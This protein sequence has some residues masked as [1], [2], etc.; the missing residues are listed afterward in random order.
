MIQDRIKTMNGKLIPWLS[1]ELE[2]RGWSHREL[3]RRA[4]I[5]QTAVS[6]VLAGERKAGWDFCAAIAGPLGETPEEI[7]RKA[8][9]IQRLNTE[10]D[11]ELIEMI[12]RLS[13][14]RR[15]MAMKLIKLLYQEQ[16]EEEAKKKRLYHEI[17]S[18]VNL[19]KALEQT[20]YQERINLLLFL[21]EWGKWKQ[22][23][24]PVNERIPVLL[25]I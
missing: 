14:D 8:D 5:S 2:N 20:T 1:R 15:E 3:A 16:I 21:F 17:E 24:F 13:S 25:S 12:G 9:L 19:L 22:E 7:F 18:R 6:T 23:G 4:N 10:V 11:Q